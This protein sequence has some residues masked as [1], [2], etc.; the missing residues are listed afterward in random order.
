MYMKSREALDLYA[1]AY[2]QTPNLRRG[3]RLALNGNAAD[4]LLVIHRGLGRGQ[5]GQVID[6]ILK[7]GGGHN[8]LTQARDQLLAFHHFEDWDVRIDCENT[9]YL[10][11]AALDV[12][13]Q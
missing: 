12:D 7:R 10:I 11:A 5:T 9:A 1:R 3:I 2:A 4:I 8:V 6:H 13:W